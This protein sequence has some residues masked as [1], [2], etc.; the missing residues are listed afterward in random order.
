MA[1]PGHRYE[2]HRSNTHEVDEQGRRLRW[3]IYDYF[4]VNGQKG[5]SFWYFAKKQDALKHYP[6]ADAKTFV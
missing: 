3:A 2:L 4:N 6:D 1:T 5:I